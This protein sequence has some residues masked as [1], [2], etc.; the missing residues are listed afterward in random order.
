MYY[1]LQWPTLNFV[2]FLLSLL[3]L[4]VLTVRALRS[5]YRTL[6]HC[7]LLTAYC[8]V[9]VHHFN[10]LI[11]YSFY[12]SEMSARRR[13]R[14]HTH[15][16]THCTVDFSAAGTPSECVDWY[17]I[18]SVSVYLRY[19][20]GVLFTISSSAHT[21]I[22]CAIFVNKLKLKRTHSHI[23]TKRNDYHRDKCENSFIVRW[24]KTANKREILILYKIEI[25]TN[26]NGAYCLMFGRWWRFGC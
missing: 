26:V 20:C 23:L 11:I 21:P 22:V 17:G 5:T 3:L 7:L 8:T 6:S 2:L 1:M 19:L 16:D 14:T 10:L 4:N 13:P 25:E 9:A 24:S 12:P 18:N 15:T